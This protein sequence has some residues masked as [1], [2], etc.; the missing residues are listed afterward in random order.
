MNMLFLC[1]ALTGFAICG[2]GVFRD[3]SGRIGDPISDDHMLLCIGLTGL[4]TTGY[5]M[6]NKLPGRP[7]ASLGNTALI[8]I[9]LVGLAIAGYGI[10]QLRNG[11]REGGNQQESLPDN[12]SALRSNAEISERLSTE[13]IHTLCYGS[14]ISLET[15][16][17]LYCTPDPLQEKHF[18]LARPTF[19]NPAIETFFKEIVDSRT[20]APK[21]RL[22][23]IVRLLELLD[24]HGHCPSVVHNTKLYDP[25]NE[26]QKG[27][28]YKHL[29][30]I[31]LW[32]HT[33]A[34]AYKFLG[35]I[36]GCMTEVDALIVSLAH[37]IGKIP[38]FH[39]KAH[40]VG[41]HTAVSAMVI[42]GWPEFTVLRNHKELTRIVRGHHLV[43]PADPSASMLKAVDQEVRQ[44]E[45]ARVMIDQ[46]DG[47]APVPAAT[48]PLR[49]IDDGRQGRRGELKSAAKSLPGLQG[50]KAAKPKGRQAQV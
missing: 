21:D 10:L 29:S 13:E 9:A 7:G 47:S 17:K 50:V 35:R 26:Y 49:S 3:I 25:E 32:E 2:F 6:F 44:I 14:E 19:E 40:T 18:P 38:V 27:E 20:T 30:K 36:P 4:A 1:I 28:S 42:N 41:D 34:V 11:N 43:T 45:L 24:K 8:G 48:G 37:D 12:A 16:S 5:G 23:V 15:V 39:D 46:F 31:P 33:L 22:S